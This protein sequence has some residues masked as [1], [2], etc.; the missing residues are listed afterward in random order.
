MD[1]TL[2]KKSWRRHIAWVVLT[3]LLIGIST[4]TLITQAARAEALSDQRSQIE[5]LQARTQEL[6]NAAAASYESGLSVGLGIRPS[7]VATDVQLIQDMVTTA[8][9]WDSGEAYEQAREA[10]LDE[11]SLSETDPFLAT[12]L[13]PATYNVDKNGTRYYYVDSLGLTSSLDGM[14]SAEPVAVT[15]TD[16]RYAVVATVDMTSTKGNGGQSLLLYVTV[17]AEGAF[18]AVEGWPAG[19]DTVRSH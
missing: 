8:F 3:L 16:Y 10:L 17:T 12:I 11:F 6:E 19:S 9:T 18:S 13:P 14:V 7:R 2:A 1:N 15:G 5:T 4:V